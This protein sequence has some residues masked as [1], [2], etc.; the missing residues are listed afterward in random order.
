MWWWLCLCFQ[1][2][3][4]SSIC[5]LVSELFVGFCYY[6]YNFYYG[7][8]CLYGCF[9]ID[10]E[11]L[12]YKFWFY[13]EVVG[14]LVYGCSY[15]DFGCSGCL[16]LWF[17]MLWWF[18]YYYYYWGGFFVWGY[19]GC[20]GYW[21][22]VILGLWV[23]GVSKLNEVWVLLV[24]FWVFGVGGF[25]YNGG[26]YSFG[27]ACGM[28]YSCYYYFWSMLFILGFYLVMVLNW[29]LCLGLLMFI[30][31]VLMWWGVYYGM[32]SEICGAGHSYMPIVVEVVPDNVFY[33]WV[34]DYKHKYD[35]A[36][37]LGDWYKLHKVS[38]F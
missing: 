10:G 38:S 34:E 32:C 6:V 30:C 12:C 8:C 18:D 20:Y 25:A 19:V 7:F 1:V 5:N 24:S 27:F 22:S 3:F 14:V 29:M 15:F 13:Y 2:L 36:T 35:I 21:S 16:F 4:L 17:V 33:S 11:G 37:R 23:Y 26:G 9:F 28:F 31:C